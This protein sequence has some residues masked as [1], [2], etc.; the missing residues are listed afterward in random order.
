MFPGEVLREATSGCGTAPTDGHRNATLPACLE[1]GGGSQLSQLSEALR[2]ASAWFPFPLFAMRTAASGYTSFVSRAS[3]HSTAR[4]SRL[5]RL[6][7]APLSRSSFLDTPSPASRVAFQRPS[8]RKR[9][10]SL[11]T[12]RKAKPKPG[13]EEW[14][15]EQKEGVLRGDGRG[16][17]R[18]NVV[19]HNAPAFPCPEDSPLGKVD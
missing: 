13:R 18:G 11:R 4:P 16:C 9:G 6:S 2:E 1:E 14:M 17:R 3:L 8:R 12:R 19:S 7:N 5:P 10:G 15:R